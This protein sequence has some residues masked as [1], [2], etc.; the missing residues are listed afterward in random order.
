M[1]ENKNVVVFDSVYEGEYKI[2]DLIKADNNCSAHFTYSRYPGKG[3]ELVVVTY[4]P[5]H[6]T[7][8]FLHSLDGNTKIEA[9]EKM[10]AHIIELKNSLKKEKSEYYNYSVEWFN[11]KLKRRE[12]STFYGKKIQDIV[13]KFFYGK[14]HDCNILIYSIKL[15]SIVN[16]DMVH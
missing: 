5:K 2:Q 15:V 14:K 11:P 9:L 3:Y 7:S 8:F 16:N 4:N 1:S 6:K 12:T 13:N 10:Y